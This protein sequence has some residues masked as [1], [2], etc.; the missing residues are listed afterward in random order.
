MYVSVSFKY[1]TLFRLDITKLTAQKNYNRNFH[2]ETY[3]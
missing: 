3:Y 2:R 1:R